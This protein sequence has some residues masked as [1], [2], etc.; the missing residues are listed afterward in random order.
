MQISMTQG[1]ARVLGVALIIGVASIAQAKTVAEDGAKAPNS[2]FSSV[3]KSLRHNC[4]SCYRRFAHFASLD[5][6]YRLH[7][8][9]EFL[10]SRN[11]RPNANFI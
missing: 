9:R 11:Y 4:E 1:L 6:V 7:N 3:N 8:C 10:L 5:R 2:D